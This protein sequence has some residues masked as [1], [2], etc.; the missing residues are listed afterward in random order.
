MF[1]AAILKPL[2]FGIPKVAFLFGGS[3]CSPCKDINLVLKLVGFME[4]PICEDRELIALP[5]RESV[6]EGAQKM[7]DIIG[8]DTG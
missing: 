3:T 2:V 1:S 8:V 7:L 6:G 4:S 5:A